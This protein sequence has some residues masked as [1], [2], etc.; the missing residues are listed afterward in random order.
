MKNDIFIRI[1]YLNKNGADYKIATTIKNANK[2]TQIYCKNN[3]IIWKQLY[4]IGRFPASEDYIIC[5]PSSFIE[6][7]K[8]CILV[9]S[10]KPD[11]IAG[12]EEGY[13]LSVNS[14]GSFDLN[15]IYVMSENAFNK[16]KL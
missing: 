5:Q 7:D 11:G 12:L 15:K 10:G 6:K 13:F 2:R 9:I 1:N 8:I 14:W 3:Q 4:M 16:L